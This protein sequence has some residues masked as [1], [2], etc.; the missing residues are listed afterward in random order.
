MR[1]L[2]A[3]VNV[4][5]HLRHLRRLLEALDLWSILAAHDIE[6]A[7]FTDAGLPLDMDDRSVWNHCQQVGWV[8]F[9]DN[10]NQDGENS[11]QKVIIDSWHNGMLPILTV[12][13][14]QRFAGGGEYADR[15]A[16]DVAEVMYG[17]RQG[18]YRN[19]PRIYVPRR[20]VNDILQHST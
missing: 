4:A 10:R 19:E 6:F 14:K 12:S 7:T 3:D 2:L 1:G 13:N 5:G 8:L 17:M 18:E 9:T 20:G 15:V 11:L 16:A